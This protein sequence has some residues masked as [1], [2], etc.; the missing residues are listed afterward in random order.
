MEQYGSRKRSTDFRRGQSLGTHDHVIVIDK[1]KTRPD[2][3][4]EAEYVAAPATLRL[5]EFKVGGKIMVTT[6]LSPKAAP[7]PELKALYRSRWHV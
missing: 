4:S 1:P 2:W 3:M 7:K 5:R 6:L